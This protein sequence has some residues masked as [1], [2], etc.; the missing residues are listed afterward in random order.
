MSNT[1][2]VVEVSK[3]EALLLQK[4]RSIKF[5]SV[6]VHI[7]DSKLIRTETTDSEIL[8]EKNDDAITIQVK[9]I[10]EDK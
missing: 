3:D 9:T 6:K 8:K 5:G 7:V 2:Y 10:I 4:L 1:R